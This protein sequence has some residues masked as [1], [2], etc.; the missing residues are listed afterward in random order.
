MAWG[1]DLL[2]AMRQT[3]VPEVPAFRGYPARIGKQVL[4][5]MIA[6]SGPALTERRPDVRDLVLNREQV[7][8]PDSI[9][10][11][12]YLCPTSTGRTTGLAWAAKDGGPVHVLVEFAMPPFGWV[13]TIE[14]QP[15]DDRPV[16]VGHLLECAVDEERL[17]EVPAIPVL[18]THEPF[19]GDYRTKNEI[20]RDVIE[21]ILVEQGHP[22]PR[23][24]A[25]RIMAAGEGER[26]FELHGEDW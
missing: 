15:L 5:T 17:I 25:A 18:P 22:A 11:S 7:A 1:H 9:R 14:G 3:P 13:L 12:M 19:P 2:D 4:A 26:F 23:L 8:V 24:E 21:N 6:A 16:A 10:L 20:R